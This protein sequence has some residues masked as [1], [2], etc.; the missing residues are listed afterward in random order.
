M[1]SIK[2]AVNLFNE[3]GH[4]EKE[5]IGFCI[6]C[7]IILYE[8]NHELLECIENV[9]ESKFLKT[10]FKKTQKYFPIRFEGI[11]HELPLISLLSTLEPDILSQGKFFD[12]EIDILKN[13][14]LEKLRR[15]RS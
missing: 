9:E 10:H 4:L 8:Q 7:K 15:Q 1:F 14:A 11:R 2:Y 5:I 3:N 13:L 6:E 12:H